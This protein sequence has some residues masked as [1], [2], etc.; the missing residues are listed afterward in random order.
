M[1]ILIPV[2]ICLAVA[3]LGGL[4]CLVIIKYTRKSHRRR[5]HSYK[6]R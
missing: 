5:R 1:A 3:V 4:I 6:R 2:L